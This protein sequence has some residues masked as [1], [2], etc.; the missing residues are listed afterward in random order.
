MKKL[1]FL[2][3]SLCAKVQICDGHPQLPYVLRY[4]I[5]K[6]AE[7]GRFCGYISSGVSTV[8]NTFHRA[9]PVAIPSYEEMP[10]MDCQER[11]PCFTIAEDLLSTTTGPGKALNLSSS[12]RKC[13]K[14]QR[15]L[16]IAVSMAY[17][18]RDW[19]PIRLIQTRVQSMSPVSVPRIALINDRL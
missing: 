5:A 7:L 6:K 3:Q 8:I 14:I 11:T 18:A 17:G 1:L 15:R 19:M 9:D 13:I 12:K 4:R 2:R 16:C 10:S